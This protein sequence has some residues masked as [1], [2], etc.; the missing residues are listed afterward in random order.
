MI[1][2]SMP[3]SKELA[4]AWRDWRRLPVPTESFRNGNKNALTFELESAI[5][6]VASYV[7]A[8]GSALMEKADYDFT[9]RGIEELHELGRIREE[10]DSGIASLE[11]HKTETYR[12][13]VDA[14]ER[15][16]KELIKHSP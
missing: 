15:L 7:Y 8:L 9:M 4:I 16:L 2:D 3:L 10:L 14:T 5:D 12:R 11:N 1:K 13:F 6:H